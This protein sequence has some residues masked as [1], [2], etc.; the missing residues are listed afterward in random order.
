MAGMTLEKDEGSMHPLNGMRR[1]TP[2]PPR[3]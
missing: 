3:P 1:S 2:L